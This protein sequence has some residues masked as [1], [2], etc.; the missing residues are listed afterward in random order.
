MLKFYRKNNLKIMKFFKTHPMYN[1][2]IHLL[3]GVGLG[4]L[5]TYPLIGPHPIRWAIVFLTIS[6]LGHLYPLV[7]GK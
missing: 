7:V 6:I 3:S 5:I 4:I 1:S 2:F